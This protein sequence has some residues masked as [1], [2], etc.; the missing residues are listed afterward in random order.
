MGER[1]LMKFLKPNEYQAQTNEIFLSL[2]EK[3][4][5]LLPFSRIEHIGSTAIDGMVSKGDLDIFLGVNKDAHAD[6]V[7]IIKSLGFEIKQGTLRT[8]AV[9]AFFCIIP[10]R[11]CHSSCGQRISL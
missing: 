3:I 11:R 2:K 8:E 6:T 7:E 9:H 4:H 1:V 10:H 5:S